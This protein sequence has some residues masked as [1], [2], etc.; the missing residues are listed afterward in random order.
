MF[1]LD[2]WRRSPRPAVIITE[3]LPVIGIDGRPFKGTFG[4]TTMNQHPARQ[5]SMAV[6]QAFAHLGGAWDSEDDKHLE[7]RADLKIRTAAARLSF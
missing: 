4:V 3:Q 6:A 5:G 7:L 1:S 2:E